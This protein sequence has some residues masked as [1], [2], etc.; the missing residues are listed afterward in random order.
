MYP[1]S[2]EIGLG[3][4]GGFQT[5]IA[6]SRFGDF[7]ARAKLGVGVV[8]RMGE[9]SRQKRRAA[10]AFHKLRRARQ[11]TEHNANQCRIR[12]VARRDVDQQF[13]AAAIA[14]R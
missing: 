3:E 5:R 9:H 2:D 4:Q 12:N 10:G 14:A 6:A 11:Q 1:W 7:Q 13:R 8:N